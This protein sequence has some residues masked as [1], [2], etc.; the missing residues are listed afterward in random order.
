ALLFLLLELGRHGRLASPLRPEQRRLLGA[1]AIVQG[2]ALA[3]HPD[4]VVFGAAW[5]WVVATQPAMRTPRVLGAVI[6]TG[7]V[8]G[9]LPY[10]YPPWIAATRPDTMFRDVL[11]PDRLLRHM[12]GAQWTATE[13]SYGW[14]MS[15]FS[16][17]PLLFWHEM[18]ALGLAG[19]VL[20]F[21]ALRSR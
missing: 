9:L 11:G 19:T 18:F 21:V 14:S 2:L 7:L 15:R 8:V 20:G 12:M 4:I 1:M 6:A 10:A 16:D 13:E 3:N 17:F 5:F